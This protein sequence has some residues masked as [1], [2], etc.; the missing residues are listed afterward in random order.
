MTPEYKQYLDEKFGRVFDHLKSIESE[1]KRTNGRVTDLEKQVL[2]IE[3]NRGVNCP[4]NREIEEMKQILRARENSL[5]EYDV[6]KKHPITVLGIVLL[7]IGV[8]ATGVFNA[9]NAL[10][11]FIRGFKI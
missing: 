2:H 5:I 9:F 4:H 6:I 3:K 1:V 8:L 11:E 7:T 10:F